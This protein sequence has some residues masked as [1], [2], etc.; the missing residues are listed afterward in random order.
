MP[1]SGP[2]SAEI[3]SES[4]RKRVQSF[5]TEPLHSAAY[6]NDVVRYLSDKPP[7]SA[8][9]RAPSPAPKESNFLY[10]Y[11]ISG[12]HS[13]QAGSYSQ[14][15][16][17]LTE[18]A[19]RADLDL[20]FFT[21]SPSA[22][23][24]EV[25]VDRLNVDLRFLHS[26]L[27]FIPNA[28]RDWYTGSNL[29]SRNRHDF[30]LLIPSIVFV[31][32]EGNSLSV[33]QLHAARRSCASQLE[34]KAHV[35]LSGGSRS[36]GQSIFR[37]VN[38]HRGD[39]IVMEQVISI[40]ITGAGKAQKGKGPCPYYRGFTD[41]TSIV[42]VWSDAGI[43]TGNI[44]I[45]DTPDFQGHSPT[46]KPGGISKTIEHCP[47]F[48]EKDMSQAA[49]AHTAVGQSDDS[50]STVQPL[51]V[52]PSRYGET[53]DWTTLREDSL[54]ML[55]ELFYFQ[56]AAACQYL[57]MLRKLISGWTA[58]LHPTGDSDPTME[59]II[60]F[61]YTKTVLVRWSTHFSTLL[62]RLDDQLSHDAG[63]THERRRH[64]Q[65]SFSP[66][67]KD[68]EY[69]RKEAETLIDLC[70]SGKATIMSSF[71]VYA[72]KRAQK[73]SSLV[74]QLTKTTNRITLIF[75]PISLVTSLFGMNFKQFGQGPLSITLWVAVSVP[76]LV[77]CIFISEWGG[78]SLRR[79]RSVLL[80][81]T[82]H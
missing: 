78:R 18:N 52:L 54:L 4:M 31:G 12:S 25:L 6:L 47:V 65:T 73:E 76:L 22:E 57:D 7:V 32:T 64:R 69:L 82:K 74:T 81:E 62:L 53:M 38:V 17:F 8:R 33:D 68:I 11:K 39:A 44:P 9:Y 70:E 23:W 58:Q 20:L 37:Q 1:D 48:F 15:S 14:A 79:G 51:A 43:D 80:S 59:F 28:Q 49:R 19:N 16:V 50:R 40:A 30:R 67:K 3:V 75:L 45:P 61:E 72:S 56:T 77:V 63:L 5:T 27:D 24:M 10:A 41:N 2:P 35:I 26:H 55:Q 13:T 36:H 66:I 21:G 46:S 60:H 29:P 34:K 42:L 71:S